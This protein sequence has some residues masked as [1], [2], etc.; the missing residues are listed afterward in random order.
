MA[1]VMNVNN[2]SNSVTSKVEIQCFFKNDVII[3]QLPVIE[4]KIM[5]I[6]GAKSLA[7]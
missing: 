6:N 5:G 7:I 3:T 2:I 1:L 4:A